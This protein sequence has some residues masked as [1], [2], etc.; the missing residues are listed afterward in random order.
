MLNK[1]L[2]SILQLL[3]DQ[4]GGEQESF[5]ILVVLSGVEVEFVLYIDQGR[6]MVLNMDQARAMNLDIDRAHTINLNL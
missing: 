2:L 4:G 5:V 6:T 1:N 3:K